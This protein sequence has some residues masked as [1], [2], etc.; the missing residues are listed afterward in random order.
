MEIIYS[1]PCAQKYAIVLWSE[2]ETLFLKFT[3][4]LSTHLTRWPVRWAIPLKY[5]DQNF[6]SLMR[7]TYST[8]LILIT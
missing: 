2:P 1:S 7:A 8:H 6:V 5:F 4:I 3:L